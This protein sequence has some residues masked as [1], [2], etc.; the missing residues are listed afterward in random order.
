MPSTLAVVFSASRR[1]G[2]ATPWKH[3][4]N[5]RLTG[6]PTPPHRSRRQ[7]D[8]LLEGAVEGGKAFAFQ[9]GDLRGMYAL[10]IPEVQQALAQAQG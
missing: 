1:D 3:F 8:R 6:A 9:V 5:H 7:A 2:F 10:F 4:G